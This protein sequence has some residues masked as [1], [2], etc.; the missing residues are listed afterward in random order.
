MQVSSK[1]SGILSHQ[2]LSLQIKTSSGDEIDLSM[3]KEA[4]AS[5]SESSDA[6]STTKTT[7]LSLSQ[8][9]K[10]HY[11]GNGISAQDQQEINDALKK[12]QPEI[13]KFM[14]KSKGDQ[15]AQNSSKPEDWVAA[16][17]ANLMPPP[18]NDNVKNYQ[19]SSLAQAFDDAMK[20]ASDSSGTSKKLC[21]DSK[22]L[23]D[24]ILALMDGKAQIQYA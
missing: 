12:F 9:Y 22:R 23:L 7:E 14:G 2:D 11:E 19:K 13:D 6:N 20:N 15:K 10:M 18:A 3:Y 5:Y 1:S 21:A 17:G 16:L 8:G 4:S 24:K